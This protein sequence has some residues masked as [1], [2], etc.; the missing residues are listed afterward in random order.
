MFLS[1]SFLQHRLKSAT[2]SALKHSYNTRLEQHIKEWWNKRS[3]K[4]NN[5]QNATYSLSINKYRSLAAVRFILECAFQHNKK[6]KCEEMLFE[7]INTNISSFRSRF[8]PV[9]DSQQKNKM[10]DEKS[11]SFP[12]L[13]ALFHYPLHLY[14]VSPAFFYR[15]HYP[16][17]LLYVSALM[18]NPNNP[19][20]LGIHPY[21]SMSCI[22]AICH[23]GIIR[24]LQM[25]VISVPKKSCKCDEWSRCKLHSK[26]L[27]Y[28]HP[29][30]LGYLSVLSNA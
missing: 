11:A 6:E 3:R 12:Y 25:D 8:L 21:P 18:L 28:G 13:M 4:W 22:E 9:F 7:H 1:S 2:P 30:S 20:G 27:Q 19:A 14:L 16:C 23:V 10:A 29:K 17:P 15:F 26:K 24:V 5:L